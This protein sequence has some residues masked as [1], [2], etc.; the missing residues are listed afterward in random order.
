M[1][2]DLIDL[3]EHC[4]VDHVD[5]LFENLKKKQHSPGHDLVELPVIGGWD[6]VENIPENKTKVCR[7]HIARVWWM[8]NGPSWSRLLPLSPDE[9]R[10]AVNSNDPRQMLVGYFANSLRE[11]NYDFRR[12]PSFGDYCSGLMASPKCPFQQHHKRQLEG[13]IVP[14]LL[15]GLDE[16]SLCWYSPQ[17]LAAA[18]RFRRV[19]A[20][21]EA[22]K[23][24]QIEFERRRAG[25]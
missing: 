14:R 10:N 16:Q 7:A 1:D 15:A 3:F 9:I 24:K 8:F 13:L 5:A 12:H 21:I 6:W 18:V 25:R 20:E 17:Q 2:Q 19:E 4:F 23:V 22:E 11:A